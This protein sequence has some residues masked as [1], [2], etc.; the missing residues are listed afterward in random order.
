ML[1]L[2]PG[3]GVFKKKIEGQQ[4]NERLPPFFTGILII[5]EPIPL[6]DRRGVFGREERQPFVF[7]V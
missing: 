2:V 6:V 3:A 7:T 5:I 1:L 4:A